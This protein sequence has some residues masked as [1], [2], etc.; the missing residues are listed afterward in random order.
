VKWTQGA[1]GGENAF[2]KRR[3]KKEAW[4]LVGAGAC[5]S[6]MGRVEGRRKP[7]LLEET[8]HANTGNGKTIQLADTPKK[9]RESGVVK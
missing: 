4:H 8:S 1:I 2:K 6:G 3:L 9:G 5:A 7:R